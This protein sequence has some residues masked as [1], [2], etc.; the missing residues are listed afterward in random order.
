[1][2]ITT[3]VTKIYIIQNNGHEEPEEVGVVVGGIKV[4]SN[5]CIML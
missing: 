4:L 2:D 1:M 3:A 5:V